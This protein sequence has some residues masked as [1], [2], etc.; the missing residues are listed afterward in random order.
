MSD[1]VCLELAWSLWKSG[2]VSLIINYIYLRFIS[3]K[4]LPFWLKIDFKRKRS[5][6]LDF[7]QFLA[8]ASFDWEL[9]EGAALPPVCLR[10]G[11]PGS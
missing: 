8:M 10:G 1:V 5:R 2:Y 6:F 4:G 11:Y 7:P 3:Q 9:L